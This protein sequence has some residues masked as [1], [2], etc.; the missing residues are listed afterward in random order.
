MSKLKDK[1]LTTEEHLIL[2]EKTIRIYQ[3]EMSMT[4]KV[5]EL[6]FLLSYFEEPNCPD[7]EWMNS[8]FIKLKKKGSWGVLVDKIT[9]SE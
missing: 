1:P 7:R 3:P 8:E 2:A 5:R 9:D 4:E 6:A